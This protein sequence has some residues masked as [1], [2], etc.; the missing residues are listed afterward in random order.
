M[1]MMMSRVMCVLAVV[2]CCACGYTMK[3]AAVVSS[4]RPDAVRAVTTEEQ[5]K[6]F[7]TSGMFGW[8]DFL[9]NASIKHMCKHPNTTVDNVKCSARGLPE[10]A[11]NVAD[12]DS[13]L[14]SQN[15]EQQQGDTNMEQQGGRQEQAA[16]PSIPN[17]P[18]VVAPSED[19]VLEEK[20]QNGMEDGKAV[21]PSSASE[22]EEHKQETEATDGATTTQ[23]QNNG[24][25]PATH[26][27]AESLSNTSE[28]ST[29]ADSNLNQQS[30]EAAGATAA[31]NSQETNSTTPT[32]P[33]NTTTEA[34][35]TTTSPV[36]V[37]NAEISSTI[38]ST[39]QNNKVN[40]DSSLSPVWMHTAAPLLIVAVL[41]FFTVY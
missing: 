33:D 11:S 26:G 16:G 35:T 17:Q 36:P 31:S 2:L 32:N 24:S 7:N 23:S 1:M 34:P 15:H 41:F 19:R 20:P 14:T 5:P 22:D 18:D 21:K 9:I 27:S 39:V 12:H 40:A 25:D 8:E 29:P 37:P 30:P 38:V 28:N 13:G 10:T 6:K 3:A 4:P